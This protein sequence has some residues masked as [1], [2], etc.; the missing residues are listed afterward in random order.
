MY[1]LVISLQIA[2]KKALG[3]HAAMV[4]QL[5]LK[6]DVCTDWMNSTI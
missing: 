3:S 2:K 6:I 1:L 4:L 5:L